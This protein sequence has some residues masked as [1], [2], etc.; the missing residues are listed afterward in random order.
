MS[1]NKDHL[2]REKTPYHEYLNYKLYEIE[3]MEL[4]IN[5]DLFYDIRQDGNNYIGYIGLNIDQMK[6]DQTLRE[7]KNIIKEKLSQLGIDKEP[8]LIFEAWKD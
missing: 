7:F 4:A 2:H 1:R 3:F 8:Y 5:L 6:D